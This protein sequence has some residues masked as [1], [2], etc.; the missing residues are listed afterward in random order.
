[1]HVLIKTFLHFGLHVNHSDLALLNFLECLTNIA[2]AIT[3]DLNV[4]IMST[5][6]VDNRFSTCLDSIQGIKD[7]FAMGQLGPRIAV[8]PLEH[9]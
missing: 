1:M 7:P 3:S 6:Q 2:R 5:A 4:K 8:F 9:S